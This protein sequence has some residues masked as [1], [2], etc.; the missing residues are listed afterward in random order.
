MRFSSYFAPIVAGFS[1]WLAAQPAFARDLRLL[2]PGHPGSLYELS[3]SEFAERVN[4]RLPEGYRLVPIAD[5]NTGDGTVLLD[6]V[7]ERRATFALASSALSTISDAFAIFELPYL[8]SSRAQIGAIRAG[9]L[10]AYL[11][12]AAG[13]KGL[14]ILGVWEDGFRHFTNDLRPV[15]TPQDLTGLRIAFADNGWRAKS[16]RALGA[17]PAPAAFSKIL[18]FLKQ[19]RAD[20]YEAPLAEITIRHLSDAQRHLTLSDHLYSP[21][22]LIAHQGA[23]DALPEPVRE[24]ISS[25]AIAMEDWIQETAIVME[26]ELVD[27]LDQRMQV[28]HAD[29]EAFQAASRPL[30]GDFIRQVPGGAKMIEIMQSAED[31]T[32]AN[33]TGQ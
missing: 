23:F 20:G 7:T 14:T 1:L 5:P 32:A 26:S 9:L 33:G 29:V 15:T 2:H 18:Q 21:A 25:E 11:Q 3:V 12:P 22:F 24:I 13:A 28:S 8:I 10:P 6:A 30:Y 4:Q 27:W 19:G 31:V 16:L 17:D